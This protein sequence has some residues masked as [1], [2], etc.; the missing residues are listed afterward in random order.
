MADGGRWGRNIRMQGNGSAVCEAGKGNWEI[1]YVWGA[2]E[3]EFIECQPAFFGARE[4]KKR[5]SSEILP[6][7]VGLEECGVDGWNR[8]GIGTSLSKQRD[9]DADMRYSADLID[10]KRR[11]DIYC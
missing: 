1:A 6:R 2:R 8:R 4:E 11:Q 3:R 5:V 9:G 10:K 7:E